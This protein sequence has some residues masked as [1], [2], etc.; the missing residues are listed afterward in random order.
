M[1]KALSA[2]VGAQYLIFGS[3]A[4]IAVKT[5]ILVIHSPC[6]RHDQRFQL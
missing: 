2:L 3:D 4:Q 6:Q 5:S 1:K